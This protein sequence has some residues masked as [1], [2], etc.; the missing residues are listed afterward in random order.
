MKRN[1]CWPSLAVLFLTLAVIPLDAGES[2]VWLD[3]LD[4]SLMR[5]ARGKPRAN[6][7]VWGSAL[8]LGEKEYKHGI[9]TN[10]AS[11]F[12]VNLKGKATRFTAIVGVD[13]CAADAAGIQ[14]KVY[15]DRELL[16]DSD[17][18]HPGGEPVGIDV[19]VSDTQILALIVED[20][21][22]A[23]DEDTADWADA[24]IYYQGK[25]PPVAIVCPAAEK[26][27]VLT[28][29]APPEPRING[30]RV[31]GVR[32]GSPFL[33]AIPATGKDPL[34]FSAQN[35]PQGLTLDAATGI[36][37]GKLDTP[38]AH[39]VT[40]HVKNDKGDT[41]RTLQ[42]V[43]GEKIALTPPMGWTSRFGRADEITQEKIKT[44][45]DALVAS[46]LARHGWT[47]VCVDDGWQGKRREPSYAL[48]PNERFPDMAGLCNY[49]RNKGL[50]VGLYSTPWRTSFQGFTGG[51][52]DDE[53][54]GF[55]VRGNSFGAVPFATQ[56]TRQYA[57]WGVDFLLYEWRPIDVEKAKECA[58]ALKASGRDITYSVANGAP[59]KDAAALK[60]C[61]HCVQTSSELF[62]RWSRLMKTVDEH[63]AWR[64]FSGPGHWTGMDILLTGISSPKL[65]PAD[66]L[67][68]NEQYAQMSLWCLNAAPLFFS[69]DPA[70]LMK[71]EDPKTQFTVGLLSN[72]EVLAIDQDALGQQ[73]RRVKADEELQVWVKDL[74]DGSKA[75]GFFNL[76]L[77][78]TNT[79]EAS[80]DELGLKGKQKV[81]DLWR[82]KNIGSFEESMKLNVNS[83]GVMLLRVFP[84]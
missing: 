80:W 38:G 36:I 41:S 48:Q 28:P 56:D 12:F 20:F 50:K 35:L 75:V 68:E 73:A 26:V 13:N 54:G 74:A 40:L 33:Y 18:M 16:F 27:G 53:K 72:D 23:N 46:D 47:Y 29:A 25:T 44:A 51:S 2:F 5:Q 8:S 10:A 58:V 4:I 57:Q 45:T 22:G 24:K 19:D 60:D 3:N 82:Q 17:A 1:T 9:G 34:A 67:T 63:L 15:G 49:I 81:R 14:F 37:K 32:T 42:I 62:D 84:E 78:G 61:A 83:H 30:P 65:C 69:M 52:A 11:Q 55:K 6:L 31:F 77:L 21:D 70:L 79:I 64:S 76:S 66:G 39:T 59:L 43:C 71:P 7:S